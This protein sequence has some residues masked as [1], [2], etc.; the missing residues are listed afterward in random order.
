MFFSFLE[1]GSFPTFASLSE[2]AGAGAMVS[3]QLKQDPCEGV[4]RAFGE[5]KKGRP[6]ENPF[7]TP[8]LVQI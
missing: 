3:V 4:G 7:A 2:A 1:D 6:Q 5:E 8:G